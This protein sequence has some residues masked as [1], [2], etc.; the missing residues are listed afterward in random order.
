V[1]YGSNRACGGYAREGNR[2]GV[3]YITNISVG[4]IA[5]LG[6]D[7]FFCEVTNCARSN[8]ACNGYLTLIGGNGSNRASGSYA[9]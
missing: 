5:C 3:F 6:G 8:N 1:G 2:A 4:L 7:V 9:R